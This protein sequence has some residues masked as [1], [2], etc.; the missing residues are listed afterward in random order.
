[1]SDYAGPGPGAFKDMN[2]SAEELFTV[3]DNTTERPEDKVDL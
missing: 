2:P 1:M 3:P